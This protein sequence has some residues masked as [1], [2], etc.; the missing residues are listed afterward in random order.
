MNTETIKQLKEYKQLLD[1]GVLS[2]EEFNAEK[3]KLLSAESSMSNKHDVPAII[4]QQEVVEYETEQIIP[5]QSMSR[6]RNLPSIAI[7]QRRDVMNARSPQEVVETCDKYLKRSTIGMIIGG[8]LV[9]IFLS[10]CSSGGGWAIF[11]AIFWAVIPAIILFV[12]AFT[13]RE[14]Y[15]SLKKKIVGMNQSDFEWL[16]EDIRER[17][18]HERGVVGKIATEA[19]QAYTQQT[20]GNM[21]FDIGKNL[22][23]R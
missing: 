21:W 20:G 7:T 10:I 18:A 11:F 9:L 6:P 15:S 8:V 16:K 5:S 17:R 3:K 13:G 22:F 4:E 23:S 1:G 19:S 12:S 14:T 2:Q